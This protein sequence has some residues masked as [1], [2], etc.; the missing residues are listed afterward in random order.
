MGT[1]ICRLEGFPLLLFLEFILLQVENFRK[2]ARTPHPHFR[3][4]SLFK[5]NVHLSQDKDTHRSSGC[6]STV[7]AVKWAES[8][9]AAVPAWSQDTFLMIWTEGVSLTNLLLTSYWPAKLLS[10]GAAFVG[11]ETLLLAKLPS[12]GCH[13]VTTATTQ[14]E[15]WGHCPSWDP[16]CSLYEG[17]FEGQGALVPRDSPCRVV[18]GHPVRCI[19]IGSIWVAT[20]IQLLLLI[21]PT[22]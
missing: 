14:R 18:L 12:L 15:K 22:V 17:L 8:S 19:L 4:T 1:L 5:F 10:S 21:H 11:W 7:S 2:R 16:G 13:G 3:V 20:F 6:N 9:A